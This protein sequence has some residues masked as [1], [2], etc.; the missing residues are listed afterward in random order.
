[1]MALKQRLDATTASGE[2]TASVEEW[3]RA[4]FGQPLTE[5]VSE[6]FRNATEQLKDSIAAL[7]VLRLLDTSKMD[8]AFTNAASDLM[9]HLR[10][11]T[12]LTRARSGPVTVAYMKDAMSAP[13]TL[14]ALDRL[15]AL[16]RVAAPAAAET[17]AEH[18][19]ELEDLS[20]L[21]RQVR[22]ACPA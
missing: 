16:R 1:M 3:V 19:G 8:Q 13:L 22:L 11:R 10:L 4:D 9:L 6:S 7:R 5:L 17:L 21:I 14:D 12:A 20:E 15:T 18:R 2:A